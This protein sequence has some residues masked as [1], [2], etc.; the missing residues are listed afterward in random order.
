MGMN[1]CPSFWS[2]V[3]P[4]YKALKEYRQ[5]FSGGSASA[6]ESGEHQVIRPRLSHCFRQLLYS[7]A[8]QVFSIK[9]TKKIN[10]WLM[11]AGDVVQRQ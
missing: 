4:Y 3:F 1:Q 10:P 11:D 2:H 9:C 6:V 5:E 8:G 7:V